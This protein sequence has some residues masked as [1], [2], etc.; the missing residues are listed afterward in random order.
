MLIIK[1]LC[2][3]AGIFIIVMGVRESIQWGPEALLG[4][5][6][7]GFALI[8][9]GKLLP[10]RIGFK[11]AIFSRLFRRKS[12]E[13][14][15]GTETA[16]ETPTLKNK[17]PRQVQASFPIK[18]LFLYFIVH[19][20]Y[21]V[22]HELGL[23]HKWGDTICI[24]SIGSVILAGLYWQY[25]LSF[26]KDRLEG[27]FPRR[28]KVTAIICLVIIVGIIGRELIEIYIMKDQTHTLS[29]MFRLTFHALLLAAL[30]LTKTYFGPILLTGTLAVLSYEI[31]MIGKLN[32]LA[33]INNAMSL[34]LDIFP[35]PFKDI[36]LVFSLIYVASTNLVD[37]FKKG[38]LDIL[39]TGNL[40]N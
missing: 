5:C 1:A 9:L 38:N 37:T 39:N 29:N 30:L 7:L 14:N 19:A 32:S 34:I 33:L 31:I 36:Y 22:L 3:A 35:D 21:L 6:A 11:S 25:L 27:K 8:V 23:S 15:A 26:K 28:L 4:A 16:V 12:K 40:H 18:I 10:S 2:A 20:G 17:N 24:Y 13:S